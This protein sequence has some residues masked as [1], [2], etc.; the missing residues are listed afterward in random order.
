[1]PEELSHFTR[2]EAVLTHA[3]NPLEARAIPTEL[4]DSI[5]QV[6]GTGSLAGRKTSTIPKCDIDA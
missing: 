2:G 6:G 4:L 5:M 3:A 1:M